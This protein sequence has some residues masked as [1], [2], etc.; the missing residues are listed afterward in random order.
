LSPSTLKDAIRPKREKVSPA[1]EMEVTEA[2]METEVIRFAS[3]KAPD[4]IV[5]APVGIT[6]LPRQLSPLETTPPVRSKLPPPEQATVAAVAGN[7]PA[8]TKKGISKESKTM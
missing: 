4:E 7:W 6:R 3:E 5:V 2:G 1:G 8:P